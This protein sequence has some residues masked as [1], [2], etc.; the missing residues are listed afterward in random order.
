MIDIG[1]GDALLVI[2]P[3]GKTMM[4]DSSNCGTNDHS[5]TAQTQI[6]NTLAAYGVTSFD[7][8][9]YSHAHSDHVNGFINFMFDNYSFGKFVYTSCNLSSSST[10]TSIISAIDSHSI[11]KYAVDTTT[12]TAQLTNWDSDVDIDVLWPTAGYSTTNANDTSLVFKMTYAGKSILF[13]GDISS[14]VDAL[15]IS[16]Y[17]SDA[18]GRLDSDILKIAHHTSNSSS[19]D[20]FISAVSPTYAFA[21]TSTNTSY[22]WPGSSTIA[23]YNTAGLTWYSTSNTSGRLFGTCYHGNITFVID[24]SGNITFDTEYSYAG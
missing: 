22:G 14:T 6:T 13:T 23:R 21:S 1:F 5:V 7:L 18:G 10:Y 19:S 4:L 24:A 20:A 8:G 12:N 17:G 11:T 9:V 2:S 15:L 3:N 16:A